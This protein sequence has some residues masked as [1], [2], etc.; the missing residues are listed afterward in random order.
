MST[1]DDG[2]RID[3]DALLASVDIVELIES[4]G[5][6]L[7]RAGKERKGL[8]P[9]HNERT[10]SFH[11]VPHKQAAFCNGCGWHGDALDF[12]M[13]F[14]RVDFREAARRL[15]AQEPATQRERRPLPPPPPDRITGKP[16]AGTDA[17]NFRSR[18][19]GQPVRTWAYRDAAGDILGYVAR[20]EY[21]DD[22]RQKKLT[23]QWTWGSTDG[24]H[25]WSWGMGHWSRPRPLYGLDRLA[26]RPDAEVLVSEGEKACD[27][28]SVLKAYVNV[29]WP[30]GCQ[31]IKHVDWSP[32]AGRRVILW[33]DA[34]E[35]GREAMLELAA[36]LT[37][38]GC[39]VRLIDP[40][41]QSDG[42]DCA[43]AV[44]S[45]WTVAQLRD[46]ARERIAPYTGT[47]A[48]PEPPAPVVAA[49]EPPAAP[50]RARPTL[51]VVD[52]GGA[53]RVVR[54]V[55]DELPPE[56][57]DDAVAQQFTAMHGDTLRFVNPWGR[58]FRWTGVRWLQ[59]DTLEAMDLA[60]HVCREAAA[61]AFADR[62]I[63]PAQQRRAAQ[64]LASA[65]TR[66]NVESLARADRRHAAT[67]AQWD[68]NPWLLNTPGGV[69]DLQTGQSRPARADD[70]QTKLT[71]ARLGGDAPRW[72]QF[73]DVVT[74]GDTELQG[75]LQRMIGYSLTGTVR[76]H[77]LFFLYGTGRNGKG[78]FL[79]TIHWLLGDYSHV[80]P[81]DT[82]TESKDQRHTTELAELRGAR[83]VTAQETEEGR[84]WAESRLKQ[85]TGGDPIT[86]RFMR[87][88]N[89][90]FD[91]QFKLII[92]G[93]HKPGLRNVDE[94]IKA[95][96]KLIPFEVFIP[97]EQRDP[98]L[99][100]KLRDEAGGI[101]RWAVEGCLE[102]QKTGLRAPASVLASTANYVESQDIMAEWIDECCTTGEFVRGQATAL[103][104]SFSAWAE[105]RSEF[106]PSQ[107]RFADRMAARGFVKEKGG[108]G[109][110]QYKG[111]ALLREAAHKP[112]RMFAD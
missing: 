59:D 95:R 91:P 78:V 26:A 72:R 94:A 37:A 85:L 87:Q 25:T 45:G 11:V 56:Y 16:P 52:G 60:R 74:A 20:Y 67:T 40:R 109:A 57:S 73:L 7:K 69:I 112:T 104:K 65:R 4:C 66:A 62:N 2:K 92:A 36:I 44:A 12:V 93:N 50:P 105:D 82:F 22:G 1:Q 34:D 5:V 83:L 42:W 18:K 30:G 84:R 39:T 101:L 51:T 10:P 64:Q 54:P 63:P 14:E 28:S 88:D 31:A 21:P 99:M 33:P 97:E 43:D 76:E 6:E 8:C 19:Y 96:L 71:H 27:A 9:F 107:T 49:P 108:S 38:L 17:P 46:W 61:T 90:T 47:T 111:I 81:I 86:A 41:G 75:F 58:W 103:F 48:E 15:G 70:H 77:A 106:V 13:A 80:S 68:A 98:L 35:P 53:E 3:V 29:T 102:W 55:I 32:L 110:V 24:G 89:F 23:P 79:N 100:E